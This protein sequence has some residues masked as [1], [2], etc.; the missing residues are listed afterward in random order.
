MWRQKKE[1][2]KRNTSSMFLLP[3][4]DEFL[5]NKELY[6]FNNVYI[7]DKGNET[8]YDRHAL[9]LLFNPTFTI[10]YQAFE[11]HVASLPIF[12]ETYDVKPGFVM[13]VLAVPEELEK[14]YESFLKGEYSKFQQAYRSPPSRR[15]RRSGVHA[16]GGP[17]AASQDA[18]NPRIEV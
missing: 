10:D 18:P 12:L 16:S 1:L 11:E 7:G 8:H 5:P 14:D 2:P 15:S 13:H 6:F 4:V 9:Y 3:M 17:A